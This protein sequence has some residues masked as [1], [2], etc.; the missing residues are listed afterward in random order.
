MKISIGLLPL[1]LIAASSQ[2]RLGKTVEECDTIYNASQLNRSRTQ[3]GVLI[4]NYGNDKIVLSCRFH[5]D[6]CFEIGVSRLDDDGKIKSLSPEEVGSIVLKNLGK[7]PKVDPEEKVVGPNTVEHSFGT[8]GRYVW[9]EEETPT[10]IIT[11]LRDNTL[12][13]SANKT[14]TAVAPQRSSSSSADTYR[15]IKAD[16][17]AVED[18][19][20]S[21]LSTCETFMRQVSDKHHDLWRQAAEL[22]LPEGQYFYGECHNYGINTPVNK[23]KA[24]EWL[25]KA[26]DQDHA[27]A[28][29]VLGVL[30]TTT[31]LT[32]DAARQGLRLW[33]RAAEH[34]LA[35]AQYILGVLYRET[36]DK[37]EIAYQYLQRAANQGHI[38]AQFELS[39]CYFR[40]RGCASSPQESLRWLQKAA[41]QDYPEA[42]YILALAYADGKIVILNFSKAA[43]L[44][45]SAA[46][47]GHAGSQCE[48]GR[49]YYIGQGVEQSYE[50][51][52][53]WF[54]AAS[55]QGHAKA[56]FLLATC[57][58]A[59]QG[60]SPDTKAAF[61]WF[62]KAADK[63][64]PEAQLG[65]ANCYATG[66]G[67]PLDP[68]SAYQ[69]FVLSSLH[70]VNVDP[71]SL[72]L[73]EQMLSPEQIREAKNWARNWKPTD[74]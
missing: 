30:L 7:I 54:L 18:Y 35:D 34:N 67:T 36:D 57:L 61:Q 3:N 26:S 19:L 31:K 28:Q 29:L 71:K 46:E 65:V 58:Q 9:R 52:V 2:A 20:K 44:L 45:R 23:S 53:P 12:A 70:G 32:E 40:G 33:E 68:Q 1:L 72:S 5:N 63:G 14:P 16:S 42:Q 27:R 38:K 51:A 74:G 62:R 43:Q 8:D 59:G 50:R 55:K 69:W 22:G 25:T 60:V 56:Q 17:Q 66:I 73:A 10:G 21:G 41:S 48:L 11:I 47:G 49:Y 39:V 24:I 64:F 6:V 37:A 15:A 4:K 13:P